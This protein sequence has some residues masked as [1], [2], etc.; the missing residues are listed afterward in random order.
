VVTPVTFD[1]KTC[2]VTGATS[3]IGQALAL[4]LA[5]QGAR[6]WA[7]GRDRDRLAATVADGDG[8]IT[9]L[10]ADLGNEEDLRRAAGYVLEDGLGVD[11]LA[12]C[13]GAI[14]RG[15]VESSTTADL[16]ALYDV[17]LR[18]PFVLTR[19][20]LPGLKS[21]H[22]QIVFVN[23]LVPSGGANDAVLY[24]SMKQAAR[25]FA[26]GLRQEVN[27]DGIR[28]V[29]VAPGRTDTPMQ[30]WVHDY[31]EREYNPD[32]LLRPEDVVGVVLSAVAVGPRGEVTDVSIRPVVKFG[33]RRP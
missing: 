4:E 8:R 25:T 18:G 20:L 2:V 29:T 15:P 26:D 23:S 10:R 13:A 16:D 28:V 11:V 30:A 21:T 1:G 33:A 17:T 32:L 14:V 12:H 5:R 31:E 22:G 27:M 7:V 3:G 24:A 19:E 9:A 6:V